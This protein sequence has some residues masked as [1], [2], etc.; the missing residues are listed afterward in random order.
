MNMFY[1]KQIFSKLIS[2]FSVLFSIVFK[3]QITVKCKKK[4]TV[5]LCNLYTS[6]KRNTFNLKF[7]LLSSE[8]SYTQFN[9]KKFG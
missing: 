5:D 9:D 4:G 8:F 2:T 1:F 6:E 3:Y 7:A